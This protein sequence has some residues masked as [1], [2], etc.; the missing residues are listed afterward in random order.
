MKTII[1]AKHAFVA[2]AERRVG[3][4]VVDDANRLLVGNLFDY[5]MDVENSS[6]DPHKGIWLMGSIGTGKTTLMSLFAEFMRNWGKG[7]KMHIC[8][9]IATDYASTGSLDAYT[10]NR[11][12]FSGRAVPMCFDD[13]GREP[14]VS[15]YFGQRLN[16]M[17]HILHVRYWLWQNEGLRTFVTT[18]CTPDNLET[19]YG[20]FVRDRVREMFNVLV[21][22]GASRRTK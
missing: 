6:L 22:D 17:Q 18:N 7:F 14:E 13:L 16:V 3:S 1:D 21:L 8:S 9:Q 11:D 2:M 4:F 12:G 10:Y 20:S 15:S 5:F 19:I